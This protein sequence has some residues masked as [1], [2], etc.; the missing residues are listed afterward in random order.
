M[1]LRAFILLLAI[2]AASTAVVDAS[3]AP[4]PP[5]RGAAGHTYG[6]IRYTPAP[7]AVTGGIVTLNATRLWESDYQWPDLN[8]VTQ[9]MWVTTSEPNPCAA[10]VEAGLTHGYLNDDQLGLIYPGRS[11]FWAEWNLNGTFKE[12]Y[13]N[14]IALSQNYTAKISRNGAGAGGGI[15]YV[16]EDSVQ[17]GASS[18]YHDYSAHDL[19]VGTESTDPYGALVSG[20]GT[21]LQKRA[22][23]NVS[24]SYGWP[25]N[26][27]LWQYPAYASWG[28]GYPTNMFDSVN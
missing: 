7:G 20:T 26:N 6:R 4:C 5:A 1:P 15:W 2:T 8:F 19:T 17:K 13:V 3:A 18:S 27:V 25:T 24:W 22:A 14:N 16:Y 10:W 28:T 21:G 9:E 23:D 11:F 12:H